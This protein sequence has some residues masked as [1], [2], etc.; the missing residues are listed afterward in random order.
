MTGQGGWPL[1]AFCDTEGVPFYGGTYF[2]PEPRQGMPSFPMVMEAV[3]KS[4]ATQREQIAEMAGRVREQLGAIGRLEPRPGELGRAVVEGAVSQLRTAADMEH[5]GFGG[6][7]KFPPSSALELMLAVGEPEPVRGDPG[8]DGGRR[9]QRPDRRRLRAL[10]GRPDLARPPLRE[11]ALRQRAARP[12]VS[13]RLPGAGRSSAGARSPSARST[14]RCAR[15]AGPRAAS[16]RR[17]TPTPRARRVGSTS[18]RRPRSG[19]RSARPGLAEL[20]DEVIAY[21]GVTEARQ[22]RGPQHPQPDR[23]PRRTGARPGSTRRARRSMRRARSASGRAS[24]T[25]ASPRGT[26]S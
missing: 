9:D 25:S 19:R 23:P 10:L 14:G 16:T 20:A 11:D 6:A 4:W 13:A 5:G 3:A 24:T 21:Y 12:G 7:P 18:G 2:P 1:T 22:L 15:C 26:R 8:R 17:S